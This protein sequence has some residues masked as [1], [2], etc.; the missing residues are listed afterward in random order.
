MQQQQQRAH[1]HQMQNASTIAPISPCVPGESGDAFESNGD[2]FESISPIADHKQRRNDISDNDVYDD[3]IGDIISLSEINGYSAEEARFAVDFMAERLR[4]RRE[5]EHEENVNVCGA[6]TC[7][8]SDAAQATVL[9]AEL[10]K[11]PLLA[12]APA[13][14]LKHAPVLVS[15][16]PRAMAV[17]VSS[18]PATATDSPTQAQGLNSIMENEMRHRL[19]QSEA[20]LSAR[21]ATASNSAGIGG[22]VSGL[23]SL[24]RTLN[25]RL[26]DLKKVVP[27][28][29]PRPVQNGSHSQ[30]A[31]PSASA[32]EQL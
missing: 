22:C 29:A 11:T 19:E 28:P 26:E 3:S 6:T 24:M 5:H 2:A 10:K 27:L 7:N 25:S 32:N 1:A 30:T 9:D 31:S 18:T 4:A 23:E 21:C 16:S 12:P 8:V 14:A 17:A 13:P 20:A 15:A